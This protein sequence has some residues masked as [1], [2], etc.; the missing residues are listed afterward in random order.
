[1]LLFIDNI[2]RFVQAGSEVSALLGRMPSQVGYQPTLE[3]EMGQLQERITST[4][5]GSVTS[6]QA[7][8][9]PADDLT[10]PAPASVFAH[11]NATTMLSRA[12][13]E[14]GIYPAVDPLDSTSTIL[15]PEVVGEEHYEVA[16]EVKEMLQRYR[17][18]QDIIAILGIDE[19]SD[20]D[21]VIVQR[22][23][24]IERF[25]S[26]P[27]NVAEQFTGTPGRLR[28]DRRDR[29]LL[30]RDPRRQARRPARVG[31]LHEGRDRRGGRGGQQERAAGQSP[32]RRRRAQQEEQ[33]EGRATE[34]E[35]RRRG[36]MART[37]FKV[38]VLTPEGEVFNDE[39]EMISTR[40][41]V[42]SI[43]VLAHHQPLLGMLEPTELRLY[44]SESDIE[45]FAQGEGYIQV[46]PEGVLVL[47]E[48]AMAP[49]DL[50][51]SDLQERLRKAEQAAERGR[52]RAPSSSAAPCATSAAGRRSSRS[53]AASGVSNAAEVAAARRRA[54]LR[55]QLAGDRLCH[56]RGLAPGVAQLRGRW[57]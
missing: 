51:T 31:L 52:G 45:R 48:E 1:M 4:R 38:E 21:K 18:L 7:I 17:E 56:P 26:Q 6:V 53:R 37:P 3:T 11:L 5:K 55:A 34:R 15:K 50:D 29:P 22:A 35:R 13:S 8:Y 2:F 14:K 44:R 43:G 49:G 12:I 25:L 9:V 20:E 57:R 39:V 30:P 16:T 32:S 24:K 36:L 33:D 46:G 47:V 41:T 40:T 28:P 54:G 42:G 10:D 19:L 27:F 23:R